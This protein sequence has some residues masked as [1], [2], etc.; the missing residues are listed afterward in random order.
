[1]EPGIWFFRFLMCVIF[2]CFIRFLRFLTR[3]GRS[4]NA[5]VR[6]LCHVSVDEVEIAAIFL[7]DPVKAGY[8]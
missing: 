2:L 6:E 3:C 7:G 8:H 4:K 5:C 1:M